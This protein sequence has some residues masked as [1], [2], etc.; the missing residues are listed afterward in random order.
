MFSSMIAIKAAKVG[1]LCESGFAYRS[2]LTRPSLRPVTLSSA[3]AERGILLL[4][5]VVLRNEGSSSLYRSSNRC[6]AALSM[7]KI[8]SWVLRD[9]ITEAHCKSPAFFVY[10]SYPP[11]QYPLFEYHNQPSLAREQK[12]K[13][14]G[15]ISFRQLNIN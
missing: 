6:F 4:L 5:F 1:K 3:A 2:R 13:K 12:M 10:L 7:T 8:F 9:I 15:L 14:T 11:L